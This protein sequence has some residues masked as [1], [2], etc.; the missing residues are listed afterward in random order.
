MVNFSIT[1]L[2]IIVIIGFIIILFIDK[3]KSNNPTNLQRV[4]QIAFALTFVSSISI[5]I[6]YIHFDLSSSNILQRIYLLLFKISIALFVLILLT[7]IL[8][9][10][11]KQTPKQ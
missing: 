3:I 5:L 10:V 6:Y 1:I 2:L 9:I 4:L 11:K 8:K 7:K